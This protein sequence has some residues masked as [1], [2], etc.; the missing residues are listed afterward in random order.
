MLAEWRK[1]FMGPILLTSNTNKNLTFLRLSKA[2]YCCRD[3]TGTNIPVLLC[4]SVL[5]SSLPTHL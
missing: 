1:R 3:E 2:S 5:K 4:S